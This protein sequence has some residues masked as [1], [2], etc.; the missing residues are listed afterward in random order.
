MV[1]LDVQSLL[2]VRDPI[3]LTNLHAMARNRKQTN[4]NPTSGAGSRAPGSKKKKNTGGGSGGNAPVA[5]GTRGFNSGPSVGRGPSGQ[6]WF[7]N[8]EFVVDVNSATSPTDASFLVINPANTATFPW[9]SRVAIGFEMYRFKRLVVSYNPTCSSS[10]SGLVV[11]GYEY[12]ATDAPPVTKQQIS[13]MEGSARNSVWSK[14]GWAMD[15]PTGWS[16][17]NPTTTSGDPR[18]ND[19]ARFFYNV[20]GATTAG[21]VGEL[22][23]SYTVEFAKPE[24]TVYAPNGLTIVTSSTMSNLAGT[25]T[26]TAGDAVFTPITAGNGTFSLKANM[27]AQVLLE[28]STVQTSTTAAAIFSSAALVRAGATIATSFASDTAAS[29]VSGSSYPGVFCMVVSVM[30]G[31]IINLV[32]SAALSAL[33]IVK[34]RS[35]MYRVTNS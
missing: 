16:Y 27:S 13:A 2:W 8:T 23:V 19:V 15:C 29:F 9:L 17:A 4:N 11:G 33:Q 7:S 20:F 28:I 35:A 10:T 18:L 34:Y 31:D 25:G 21:T 22:T 30:P 5:V 24:M 3:L 32:A 1:P 12:D 6:T 26:T 14:G